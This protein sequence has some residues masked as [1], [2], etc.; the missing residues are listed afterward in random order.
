MKTCLTGLQIKRAA[1]KKLT[2]QVM[3]KDTHVIYSID[4]IFG[5]IQAL[6]KARISPSK[7]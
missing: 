2:A 6:K 5:F 7:S 1:S 3:E 4:G